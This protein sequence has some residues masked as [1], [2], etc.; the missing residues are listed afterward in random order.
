MNKYQGCRFI[1][2]TFN[3]V[4]TDVTSEEIIVIKSLYINYHFE[5]NIHC[6]EK[7]YTEQNVGTELIIKKKV[8]Q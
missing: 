5:N 2:S 7:V 6:I 8:K 3:N 1:I 4:K